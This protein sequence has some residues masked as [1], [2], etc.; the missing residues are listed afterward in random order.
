[1]APTLPSAGA[2]VF[3]MTETPVAVAAPDPRVLARDAIARHLGQPTG[4]AQSAV[5]ELTD[6]EVAGVV[7]ATSDRHTARDE[8][9]RVLTQAYDRRR[10]AAQREAGVKGEFLR[11]RGLAE[12]VLSQSL[13]MSVAGAA[14]VSRRLSEGE[15]TLLA[16]LDGL[17]DVAEVAAAVLDRAERQAAQGSGVGDRESEEAIDEATDVIPGES[18]PVVSPETGTA[19][20]LAVNHQPAPGQS[21]AEV[22]AAEAA[23]DVTVEEPAPAEPPARPAKGKPRK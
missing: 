19:E 5:N 13:H 21:F 17:D 16:E 18:T 15:L 2:A 1:M 9:K 8:I 4:G 6:E 11:R 7:A 14:Q 22:H 12:R 20:G 10:V 3:T 23:T